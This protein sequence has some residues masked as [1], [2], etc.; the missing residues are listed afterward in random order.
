MAKKVVEQTVRDLALNLS[1][2]TD[3]S[4]L[5]ETDRRTL[6]GRDVVELRV[7]LRQ[8]PCLMRI[9][10]WSLL[11]RNRLAAVLGRAGLELATDEWFT[12]SQQFPSCGCWVMRRA[13]NQN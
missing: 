10:D 6:L 1:H 12:P 8:S 11:Y 7:F 2:A 4:V 3:C 5:I 13:R 9:D